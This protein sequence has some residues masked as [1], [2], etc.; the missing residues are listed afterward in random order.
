MLSI[1][2]SFL[3]FPCAHAQYFD[4]AGECASLHGYDR[5]IHLTISGIPNERGWIFPFGGFKFIKGFLEY[6][7]DHTALL[8]ADDPRIDS[9]PRE[10]LDQGGI[11][12]KLRTLP[13]GVSMEMSSLFIWEQLNPY[14]IQNSDSDVFLSKV[15]VR[16][17]ERNSGSLEVSEKQAKSQKVDIKVPI[18]ERFWEYKPPHQA[19]KDLG[20][21]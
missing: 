19:M 7:F 20:L 12:Y 15:E 6:Y 10:Q 16:E 9:I 5:S 3:N 13:Y 14:I 4:K 18:Q 2:K 8:S 11:L 21:I 17:H 1:T